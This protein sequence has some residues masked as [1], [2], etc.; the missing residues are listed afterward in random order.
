MLHI[1]TMNKVCLIA[2]SDS[3]IFY[4]SGRDKPESG[5]NATDKTPI[6]ECHRF[7]CLGVGESIFCTRALGVRVLSLAFC[8]EFIIRL[9]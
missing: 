9:I 1:Y 7:L 5:H 4:S 2:D 8:P 3:Q 6:Y